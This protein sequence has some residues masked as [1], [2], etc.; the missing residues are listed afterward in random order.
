[1]IELFR[2]LFLCV[3]YIIGILFYVM[4][5][6]F[7]MCLGFFVAMFGVGSKGFASIF[8]WMF[9]LVWLPFKIFAMMFGLL[10]FKHNKF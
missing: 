4:L 8:K 2:V 6:I 7:R 3:A 5:G 9:A 10:C 1:M